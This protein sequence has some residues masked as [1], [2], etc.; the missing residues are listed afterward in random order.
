MKLINKVYLDLWKYSLIYFILIISIL[1]SVGYLTIIERKILRLTQ[2][3]LGPNKTLLKGLGQPILDGVKLL[4]KV[5]LKAF[6]IYYITFR[7]VAFIVIF[8]A[9]LIWMLYPF[10]LWY[11]KP[12]TLLWFLI[13]LGILSYCILIIGWRSLNKYRRIGGNRRLAQTLSLEIVL[14]IIII[15]YFTLNNKLSRLFL[16]YY[17]SFTSPALGFLLAIL[18]TIEI[19]RSPLDLAE[20]ERELVRGYNTE[21]SRV[22]FV[23][24]FLAEYRNIIFLVFFW[25][26]ISLKPHFMLLNIIIWIT[27]I[28]RSC[29]P[30][31]RYDTIIKLT[32]FK[33][34]PLGLLAWTYILCLKL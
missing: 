30:R 31:M 18:F 21:Y 23:T 9:L 20:A 25:T 7:V 4:K 16:E 13:I 26:L 2:I 15:T 28:L 27:L 32:W 22:S 10:Y 5:E 29:Y 33:I 17:T 24:I 6:S 14:T 19:Q 1:V 34:A 11:N 8:C 12:L 3:R